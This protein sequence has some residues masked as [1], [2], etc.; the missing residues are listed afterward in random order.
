MGEPLATAVAE[1]ARGTSLPEHLAHP[2]RA[3][4]RCCCA[5][6]YLASRSAPWGFD[7]FEIPSGRVYIML[8]YIVLCYDVISYPI[9]LL[10][11]YILG[12]PSNKGALA[13][14]ST[15]VTPPRAIEAHGHTP[16]SAMQHASPFSYV[17]QH[18][19]HENPLRQQFCG[20]PRSFRGFTPSQ[21]RT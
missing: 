17:H 21:R 11:Y 4:I 16:R 6:C 13:P 10:V 19:P 1:I 15:T 14:R 12:W 7:A 9:T 5:T 3:K 2:P 18:F 20:I 8:Y